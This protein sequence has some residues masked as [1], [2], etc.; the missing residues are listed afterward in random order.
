MYAVRY[1]ALLELEVLWLY[2]VLEIL[3]GVKEYLKEVSQD[4]ACSVSRT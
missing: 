2:Y 3:R 1:T 4:L